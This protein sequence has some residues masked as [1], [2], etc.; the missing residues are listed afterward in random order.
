M[1]IRSVVF[2]VPYFDLNRSPGVRGIVGWGSHD[3]G[4]ALIA[5]PASLLDEIT[6]RFGSYPAMA[7]MYACPA[8]SA[9][10]CEQMG[11]VLVE[12]IELRRRVA[13]WL[14]SQTVQDCDL[15]YLA[16]GE[17]H[18]AIEGL[19][20]GI[21]PLHPL[22]NHQ[23]APFAA[24]AL[25]D[26]Y[27]AVDRLIGDLNHA[28][29]NA[30]TFVFAPGGMGINDSDLQSMV[31]LPELLFRHAF[32]RALIQVPDLWQDTR[33]R[34]LRKR[35]DQ[36][37]SAA[38]N[39]C[40][41]NP[42][43]QRL[44]LL[45]RVRRRISALK[46][47][48]Q[49]N[50]NWHPAT[51]YARYWPNMP[52]FGLP[53]F[54]DGRIRINLV[55]RERH[56]LVTPQK[57]A[58]VCDEIEAL[59]RGCRDPRTGNPAVTSIL[60]PHIDN[61]MHLNDSDADMTVVWQDCID[62]FDHPIHGTIGPVPFRRT[63]GHTGRYGMALIANSNIAPGQYGVRSSHDVLPTLADLLQTRIPGPV[64]GQ[65]LFERAPCT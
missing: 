19:W 62:A 21:D 35:P 12:G 65:S 28:Q 58:Y 49:S 30:P 9:E 57:Y 32:G 2:D 43:Q 4:T 25:Y 26:V 61:P 51:F 40:Y 56:G 53:S 64:S 13:L 8:Y 3:A 17:V 23:S 11:K 22:H 29:K 20:H 5:N 50:L 34:I 38:I 6:A 18:A 46:R 41:R 45:A 7:W 52:A 1:P 47:S 54:F 15:F 39:A 31:L 16:I 42:Q 27:E 63:G 14:L 10:G 60:R 59:L 33:N 36:S 48:T 24:K 44:T 37:W 55:G